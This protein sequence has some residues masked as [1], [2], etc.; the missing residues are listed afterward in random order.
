MARKIDESHCEQTSHL[1][2][3]TGSVVRCG[4]VVQRCVIVRGYV[5]QRFDGG[6]VGVGVGC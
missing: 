1:L 5:Y 3:E 6:F 4:G 2:D